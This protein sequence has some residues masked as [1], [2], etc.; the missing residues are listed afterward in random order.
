VC[1]Q[2]DKLSER[3]TELSELKSQLSNLKRLS[4]QQSF[5]L[6]EMRQKLRVQ[7]LPKREVAVQDSAVQCN[8]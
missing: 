3:D 2:T 7:E 8:T 5:E 1:N 4:A 6:L